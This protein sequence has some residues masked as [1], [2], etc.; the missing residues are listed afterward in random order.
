M[1]G[2]HAVGQ[3]SVVDAV[4][5]QLHQQLADGTWAVGER[6]PTEQEL[7]GSLGVSRAVV[8]E[9]VR[10]LVHLGMLEARQG[11]GTYVIS[12][13]D[14]LPLLRPNEGTVRDVLE[15]QL[16]LDVQAA[17]L[18]ATR[19]SETDLV[20]LR[21]L[22]ARRDGAE[23]AEEFGADD[24]AFHLAV[25]DAARNPVL[26]AMYRF[27]VRRLRESLAMVRA[28]GV[29]DVDRAHD[30]DEEPHRRLVRAI[31][32]GDVAGAR[33]A[34]RAA[35]EPTLAVLDDAPLHRPDRGSA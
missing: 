19:R 11:S 4:I 13:A 23:G 20:R 15:T 16:A 5:Q 6:I 7:S 29:G 24:A 30:P 33:R 21:E 9:A 3:R 2:L 12:R 1:A 10:A 25:V 14:P 17:G 26:A 27:F 18:A 22:L 31:E 8:R 35:V 34:A 32:L 28:H